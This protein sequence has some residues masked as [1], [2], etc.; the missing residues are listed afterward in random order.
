MIVGRVCYYFL[1]IF[2]II[3]IFLKKL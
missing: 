2:E 3:S 1:H